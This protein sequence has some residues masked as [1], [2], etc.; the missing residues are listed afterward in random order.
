MKKIQFA[1]LDVNLD[2]GHTMIAEILEGIIVHYL[3]ISDHGESL[4]T[5]R[6]KEAGI[7]MIAP[8]YFVEVKMWE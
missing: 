5:H 4:L 6:R 7:W 2:L 1:S 8:Y 3:P